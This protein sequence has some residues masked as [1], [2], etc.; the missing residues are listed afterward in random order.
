L[1]QEAQMYKKREA[2][3]IKEKSLEDKKFVDPETQQKY[4][5]FYQ[6]PPQKF[7]EAEQDQNP[8][9]VGSHWGKS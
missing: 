6:L 7:P 5:Q 3:G 4:S 1:V 2:M 8:A 9:A